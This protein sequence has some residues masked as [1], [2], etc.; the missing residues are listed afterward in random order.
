MAGT[1]PKAESSAAADAHRAFILGVATSVGLSM[2]STDKDPD[3]V[4]VD[5]APIE[6]V[7]AVLR[8]KRLLPEPGEEE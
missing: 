5:E 2:V 3:G 1:Q 4:P 6:A 7:E 8:R